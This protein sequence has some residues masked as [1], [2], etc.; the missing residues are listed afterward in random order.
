MADPKRRVI[1]AV[2][3]GWRGSAAD[4]AGKAVRRLAAEYETNP[5]DLIVAIGPSIGQCCFEVGPEVA[6]EFEPYVQGSAS[7]DHVDLVEVN[8]RQLVAAGV[9]PGNIEVS[10]LCTACSPE[11]FHSWRRDRERAGRMVAAIQIKPA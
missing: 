7:R 5:I 10:G 11:Q 9:E 8:V 6:A 2:H 4:I 1:G 3:A